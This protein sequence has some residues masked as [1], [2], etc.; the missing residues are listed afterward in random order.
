M[1]PEDALAL[2]AS[3]APPQNLWQ[4]EVWPRLKVAPLLKTL[5]LSVFLTIFFIIYLWLLK[6]PMYA[7]TRMPLTA[8]DRV[9][10]FQ[11]ETLLLY[12]SLWVYVGLPALLFGSHK[13]LI[14]YGFAACVLCLI[15]LACFYLWPTAIARPDID[16]VRYP[17][18]A[19]LQHIDAAGNA[20]PS[21]HVAS[22]VFSAIWLDRLLRAMRSSAAL[23]VLSALWCFGIVYST[24]ATKQHVALD[25]LA[26]AALAVLVTMAAFPLKRQL[27]P[28]A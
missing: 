2:P 26:G 24:L 25:A 9:I 10:P 16:W 15:G 8:L 21:L 17:A 6:H 7:V 19:F 27:G 14:G 11:P 13:S 18:F 4:R 23:R 28:P 3:V 5:G 20:C 1:N 12:V 22:A